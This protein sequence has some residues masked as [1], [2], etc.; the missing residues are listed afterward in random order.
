MPI[1]RKQFLKALGTLAFLPSATAFSKP[2]VEN[3]QSFTPVIGSR[4]V[5][6]STQNS[7]AKVYFTRNIDA[8]HLIK[9]YN[10]V[11]G[12]IIVK[13]G[14]KIH[15]GERNGPNILPRDLV[16][17]FQAQIPN[18]ALVETNTL[19]FGD[20]HTTEKHLE[21]LKVN[22]W[23]FCPVDI[24]DADGAVVFPIKGGKHLKEIS[25]GKNLPNYDSL[26]V[27]THFKGHG[28]GGFGG[29][30]KNIAIGCAD[31]RR[32]KLRIHAAIDIRVPF[33]D[34]LRKELFMEYMA[35]AAKGVCDHFGNNMCYLNVLRRMSV[36][37]DC[38]GKRAKEPTIP[39]IGILAS[40][41]ILAIDQASVDLVYHTPHGLN[42][43]LVER[44]E[45]KKGLR[46]LSYMKELKMGKPQYELICIDE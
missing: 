36:D 41:D 34:W 6:S 40:T 18:S 4:Q 45:S 28:V 37:C 8:D 16:K 15:T 43:D 27:L 44:I 29:A 22:G 11:N 12:N 14:I 17:A 38:S 19:Y 30:M 26:V 25:V 1:T 42:K 20:R 9:L 35:E 5:E 31:G 3:I 21:T 2:L 33:Y 39:D 24:L 32:G 10:L 7:P 46:Q 23:T 13:V